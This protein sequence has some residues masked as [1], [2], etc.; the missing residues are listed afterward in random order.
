MSRVVELRQY[1]LRPGAF[2]TLAGLFERELRAGQEA[3]G[4]RVLGVFR[5]LDDPDRFVWMRSFPDMESR[6]R[7]LEAFYTGAV[8]KRNSAAANATMISSDD[9][10]LLRPL[11]GPEAPPAQPGETLT[12]TIFPLREPAESGF[13]SLLDRALEPLFADDGAPPLA[14]LVTDPSP[15]TF[16][17]LPVREG[18]LVLVRFST[19]AA[20]GA[21][22]RR[23]ADL[24]RLA[25]PLLAAP[26]ALLRLAA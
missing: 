12:A 18:E 17:A 4:M 26:P 9:V 11:D 6:R 1:T 25:G 24:E 13:A 22:E 23:A 5:D 15:N 2:D 16:P 8:W 7:S 20:Q 14:R 19:A 21:L 3:A 10:F